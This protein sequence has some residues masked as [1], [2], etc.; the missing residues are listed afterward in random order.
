[1]NNCDKL[2][3]LLDVQLFVEVWRREHSRTVLRA[4]SEVFADVEST[5][6]ETVEIDEDEV[7][8]DIIDQE[9]AS[10]RDDSKLCN[11]LC[12]SDL[13]NLDVEMEECDESGN[14][15]RSVTSLIGSLMP[16]N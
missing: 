12:E 14:Q 15:Q 6:L 7:E 5:E 2:R 16:N 4:I 11:L 3:T 8:F 10:L 9:W 13:M 1:M